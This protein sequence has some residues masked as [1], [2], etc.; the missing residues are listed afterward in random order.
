MLE[1]ILFLCGAA[2]GAGAVAYRMKGSRTWR[3][4]GAEILGGGP[5]NPKPPV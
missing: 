2:A 3:E 5:G 4:M 1:L